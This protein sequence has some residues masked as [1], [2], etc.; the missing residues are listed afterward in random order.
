MKHL[1]PCTR[2]FLAYPISHLDRSPYYFTR[3]APKFMDSVPHWVPTF[4][5]IPAALDTYFINILDTTH[6][7]YC[8]GRAP[9]DSL[10]P[11]AAF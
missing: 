6:F 5:P 10:E 11:T 8:T 1:S 4:R 2:P 9:I 7:S 3:V